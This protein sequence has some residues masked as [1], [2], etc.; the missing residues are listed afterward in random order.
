MNDKIYYS[1]TNGEQLQLGPD[2][3]LHG[4]NSNLSYVVNSVNQVI[5]L[6]SPL[7][8]SKLYLGEN[9]IF[10]SKYD[11]VKYMVNDGKI[12]P[13]VSPIHGGELSKGDNGLY[14]SPYDDNQ[15]MVSSDGIIKP[16]ID[17]FNGGNLYQNQDGTYQSTITGKNFIFDDSKNA[18]IPL[19]IP[20][21]TAENA[22]IEN[23]VLVGNESGRKFEVD[24][25]GTV[26]TPQEI[27]FREIKQK[28]L[29]R[30]DQME[31]DGTI[32]QYFDEIEQKTKNK[33]PMTEEK[34]RDIITGN[35]SIKDMNPA[36]MQTTNNQINQQDEPLSISSSM[37]TI[38]DFLDTNGITNEVNFVN[39]LKQLGMD[40][41]IADSLGK[42][43]GTN[44]M[45]ILGQDY[46]AQLLLI[47]KDN[48]DK[49]FYIPT[50]KTSKTAMTFELMR[51]GS[52]RI[53]EN[54]HSP[55]MVHG[56][57]YGDVNIVDMNMN[58]D[59]DLNLIESHHQ[60][61]P[62]DGLQ[63]IDSKPRFVVTSSKRP[64]TITQ[65]GEIKQEMGINKQL[66]LDIME[67][68]RLK[69]IQNIEYL[70]GKNQEL[71]EMGFDEKYF[72]KPNISGINYDINGNETFYE[73]EDL[74]YIPELG[75]YINNLALINNYNITSEKHDRTL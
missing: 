33:V 28:E 61:M 60:V 32:E 42:S 58:N 14:S 25:D 11:N 57:R 73:S 6:K 54:Q 27:A 63:P 10:Y 37:M 53:I 65:N 43:N 22:H 44:F 40:G 15:Y 12:V 18:F 67:N 20:D 71:R 1:P 4:M 72:T 48:G 66:I 38:Q 21:D 69:P 7:N 68:G 24:K 46:S 56:I 36:G 23:G 2:G 17:P 49:S 31:R 47:N 29:E 59:G 30:F 75:I 13:L 41:R 35:L 51:G 16:L 45:S 26:M 3:L 55:V 5:P 62:S 9:G 64:I 50:T 8:A 70:E 74:G 52:I 34:I 39:Y 19:Y